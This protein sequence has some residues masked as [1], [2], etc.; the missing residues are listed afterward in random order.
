[1]EESHLSRKSSVE[2]LKKRSFRTKA[3][4][5]VLG[6]VDKI[7]G[8]GIDDLHLAGWG[9]PLVTLYYSVIAIITIT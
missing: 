2:L 9:I 3:K 8:V 1:M 7:G 4:D 6:S 5:T